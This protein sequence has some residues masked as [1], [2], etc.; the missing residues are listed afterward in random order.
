VYLDLRYF[1]VGGLW[2]FNRN[3]PNAHR[4][5]YVLEVLV[6]D[7]VDNVT[8]KLVHAHVILFN[9]RIQFDHPTV[10]TWASYTAIDPSFMILIDASFAVSHPQILP[11]DN[12]KTLLKSLKQQIN[13]KNE[14]NSN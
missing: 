6:S 11:P 1:G 10:V 14:T 13:N 3:L 7:Y 8:R 2:Y 4:T 9:E 5:A 12:Q